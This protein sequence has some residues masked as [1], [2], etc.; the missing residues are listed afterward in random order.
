MNT[1]DCP[2]LQTL[3]AYLLGDLDE[4]AFTRVARHL[5][6]CPHCQEQADRLDSQDD[7]V[8]AGLRV[9]IQSPDQTA[10]GDRTEAASSDE[11]ADSTAAIDQWGD[12]RIAREIGRGGM[13]VVYEA[14]QGSLGRHV[15]LKLLPERGNLAR[16]HREAKAAGRLHHTNIVP[17]FGVGEHDGRHYYI[18]QFIAGRGLDTLI[19]ERNRGAS[20]P[21]DDREI[22]RI[23]VQAAEALAYSHAHGVVHRDIKPSNVLIDERSSVW[24]T[25][26]GLAHDASDTATLT[27]T[28]DFVGTLR[29]S[30][31]ERIG[32]HGDARVDLYGL[33]LT[34]YELACGRPAFA[35]ADRGVL[36]HQLLHA[37]PVTPRRL[38]RACRAT[39]RRSSSRRWRATRPR[40]TPRP[41]RWPTT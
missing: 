40:A 11:P 14:Y 41:P 3:S 10:G 15:A 7:T 26:F 8:L 1:I 27:H 19:A 31:P 22:A 24:I 21:F 17:V 12:F 20:L 38:S 39:S 5:D 35:E 33:G 6:A 18:M 13:G 34:L 4:P 36:L 37:D 9:M 30:A 28:G 32:G 16:F 29:Y 2:D 25:D 23:G